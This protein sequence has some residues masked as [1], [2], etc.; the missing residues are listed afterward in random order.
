MAP[1]GIRKPL[2]HIL[3]DT[4]LGSEELLTPEVTSAPSV[5]PGSA[6]EAL[7]SPALPPGGHGAQS[8]QIRLALYLPQACSLLWSKADAGPA[9]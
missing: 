8:L 7:C 6:A 1:S 9:A 3:R 4:A 5:T 2:R